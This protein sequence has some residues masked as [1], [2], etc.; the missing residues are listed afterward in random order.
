MSYRVIEGFPLSP[1]QARAWQLQQPASRLYAQ[2]II[3]IE[4][5]LD[6][7]ALERAVA[8]VAQRHEIFRTTFRALPEMQV[9]V[10]VIGEGATPAFR[11]ID[12]RACREAEAASLI[13]RVA[14]HDRDRTWDFE[15]GPLLRCALIVQ[16]ADRQTLVLTL[17]SL[18]ADHRTLTNV[19]DEIAMAYGGARRDRQPAEAAA[20]ALDPD[21]LQYV[22]VAEWQRDMVAS[23]DDPDA[24]RFWQQ[25]EGRPTER[26]ALRALFAETVGDRFEPAV[27][28]RDI[29]QR[30]LTRI[31][32]VTARERVSEAAFWMT[33]WT[34]LLRRL[35][36]ETD[37]VIGRVFH[38]RRYPEMQEGMGPVARCVPIRCRADGAMTFAML[39]GRLHQAITDADTRQE[40]Y[41]APPRERPL[42]FEVHDW[43]G[44]RR[45]GELRFRIEQQVC[46]L[47]P[48]ILKLACGCR[49]S[50]RR[51]E[52]HLDRSCVSL[53]TAEWLADHLLRIVEGVLV[54]PHASIEALDLLTESQRRQLL[55][56]GNASGVASIAVDRPLPWHV[57]AQAARTPDAAAV[58]TS[59]G[60]V[61]L[62]YVELTRWADAIAAA[63]R[64]RGVSV[65]S[66]VPVLMRRST[67]LLAALLG[68]MKAG[69]AYVPL[70]P[71]DPAA[72][73]AAVLD[74]ANA[75]VVLTDAGALDQ[76]WTEAIRGRELRVP[77]RYPAATAP[78][79]RDP[80]DS[81]ALALHLDQLAYVIY[82][83]GSSGQ[84]KGVLITHRGLMNYL[85]WA[86]QAYRISAGGGAPL[87]S[88]IAFDLSVT[89][90]FAPLLAGA[91]VTLAPDA[92]STSGD[93]L[94]HTLR[95]P[96]DRFDVVK[97][98]PAHL[99]VLAWQVPPQL[100][101]SRTRSLIVGGEALHAEALRALREA[102]TDLRIY[103]EY[104]PTETVVG[105]C[106][107]E[108]TPE[109]AP[110]GVVPIGRPIANTR[111]YVVDRQGRL[112][113]PGVDGELRIGGAGLARGYLHR[114]D[115]TADRFVP[116]PFGEAPGSRLYRTGDIVRWRTDGT[117]VYIGRADDQ[118]KLR[119]YRIE[120]GEI[121]SALRR[122]PGVR[123]VAVLVRED[124][125]GD[126]RLVAY[127]VADH[128][129]RLSAEAIGQALGLQLPHYMLP[130]AVV[131]LDA[132]PVTRGGKIDRPALPPPNR[133]ADRSVAI[134]RPATPVEDVLAAI[135]IDVLDLDEVSVEDNFFASGGDSIRAIQLCARAAQRGLALTH[136]QLFAHQ[137][138]AALARLVG[139]DQQVPRPP[140]TPP[141]FSLVSDTDRETL[142]EGLDDAYPM[143][144]LQ[145]GM[146][147]HTELAPDTAIFHD[148]HSFRVRAPLDL[149]GLR[150][151]LDE[152]TKRHPV[153]RTAFELSRYRVPLQLVFR[154][155]VAP[156]DVTDLRAL[157]PDAQAGEVAAWLRAERMRPFEWRAAPLLRF[158]VHWLRDDQFQFTMSFHHAMLDGW[159]AA[160]LL[161]ELF[162]RS[163]AIHEA[164]EAPAPAAL[165]CSFRDFIALERQAEES[166]ECRQ[167]WRDQLARAPLVRLPRREDDAT[168]AAETAAIDG[169]MGIVPVEI[170]ESVFEGLRRLV[171]VAALP[172]KSIAL[173]AH[174]KVLAVETNQP[175]VVTGLVSHG[176]P[177]G[178]DGDR[179]LGLFLNTVPCVIDVGSRSWRDLAQAA[180]DAERRLWP[181]RRYPLA[182]LQ[183]DREGPVFDVGFNFMHYH[184]YQ[185][186][187]QSD[188]VRV[189]GYAGYEETD[190]PLTAN[191]YLD[192]NTTRLRLSL[193]YRPTEFSE[194]QIGRI[195][196]RYRQ[197][198]IAIAANA[199]DDHTATT[200]LTAAERDLVVGAWSRGVDGM[201]AASLVA[202]LDAQAARTPAAIAVTCGGRTL[203]FRELHARANQL[204]RHL[205]TM[206]IGREMLVGVWL[207]RSPELL[208][209]LLG[210]LKAGA[211]YVPLDPTNPAARVQSIL[212]DARPRVVLTRSELI[213][214]LPAHDGVNLRIDA[215]AAAF[216]SQSIEPLPAASDEAD[217]ADDL[218]YVIYTSGST[219]IPKG[220]LVRRQGLHNYLQWAL[221][222]Y[223][224]QPG[225]GAPLHSSAAF[226]LSVTSLFAPL[227]TGGT[228][229]MAPEGALGTELA[230]VLRG[231]EHFGLIKLTPAHLQAL[232][233]QLPP[234]ALGTR[235][236][237]LVI[238]G[239]ALHAETLA[240]W[241]EA[242]PGLRLY[243]EYGPT[244]TVVGSV[245][246]DATGEASARGPVPIGRPIANTQI[247]VLGEHGHPVPP[248]V[249]GELCIGGV[250]VARGYLNRPELTADRF[251]PDP[252]GT[253]PGARLYRTG[254]IVR[255]RSD[256]IL[257]YLG[258]A[259][260]QVKIRGHRVELGEIESAL[261]QQAG[262]RDAV[263]L[264]RDVAP[265]DRRLVAYLVATDAPLT[266]ETLQQS[267]RQLLPDALIP[268][269]MVWLDELP[270]TVNGK[271]D[272][273]RLP[274]PGGERPTL[275]DGYVAPRTPTEE[276]LAAIWAEVLRLDRV[277][278]ED[279]FFALGG[280]SLIAMQVAARVR[281]AFRVDLP[282][283]RLF[284]T[285]RVAPLA[286][287][288]DEGRIEAATS[289]ADLVEQ[290]ISIGAAAAV[291]DVERLLD[292][293]EALDSD[294]VR[295]LLGDQV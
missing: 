162:Q 234:D 197:A 54:D 280:H 113:P 120:L 134:V 39:A 105:S 142:P 270:L 150:R 6:A 165:Q 210:I 56:T 61:V 170:P 250:G 196:D 119:G 206:G 127:L 133:A 253:T 90:L 292:E 53:A 240:A 205:Q 129:L 209:A 293:L 242:G 283:R 89:S 43:P 248:R 111:V 195:A 2:S 174:A 62:T 219:G 123:E 166:P 13:A 76:P 204:A 128:A 67:G 291:S 202:S 22:E 163:R 50:S 144:A 273:R 184:V 84:P 114:P 27:I 211:A 57:D 91:P 177:E 279:D 277:G 158:H 104:G 188:S 267:L 23:E 74:D 92:A 288:I 98:T 236:R 295:T 93:A 259:D 153:L 83:S 251:V 189:E 112:V 11:R 223:G 55:E 263:A 194:E 269:A 213:A 161:T 40:F 282:L 217:D 65:E 172:L 258:R 156:L 192:P 121:E 68:V 135:W 79:T 42:A 8:I 33:C 173:A 118:V 86:V 178:V 103:N 180:F 216:E 29:E 224:L 233:L 228:I 266:S 169:G 46:H 99:Q 139:F 137:T 116:D 37:L 16:A 72:R 237:A 268:S 28:A 260:Q 88:S 60:G 82:T 32:S 52:L 246:H 229:T 81:R 4:G 19:V 190:L 101:A 208:I 1:Q 51:L 167:F 80:A 20:A 244:E 222:A 181:H 14:A 243:N 201:P 73:I 154:E 286:R 238:G 183:R 17:P 252:F 285:P 18:C 38:G 294:S 164:P 140:A 110:A 87:H 225:D 5:A 141:A 290:Q 136:D 97:I 85:L 160:S 34:V 31:N 227:L 9:P 159:S 59:G 239:E 41:D 193:H 207:D 47:E 281:D 149:D 109:M 221:Q 230:E 48:F 212:A 255:W 70:D 182:R 191:F 262:I 45:S 71:A 214:R 171:R 249:A 179:V 254:D 106:V 186:V 235:T 148:L 78:D 152:V 138:I 115:L 200:L 66:R 26:S 215:D 96:G 131:W 30:Q 36:G 107:F 232:G 199:D 175:L 15:D 124:A 117:L 203:T 287:L 102:G 10:Q 95:E 284:E 168:L 157:E 143:G 146:V 132:L 44:V 49:D 94:V 75:A 185:G 155:V 247:Y 7:D 278:M 226:D 77:D 3:A 108:V 64:A 272:R 25:Q 21:P 151:S 63:L 264:L 35:L 69:A 220:V 198:L 245:A 100:V 145:S 265:D 276:R 231:H 58:R 130:Q 24:R 271:V 12:A 274:A 122:L 176:R 218:A 257:D 261:R 187:Q 256:G 147:F 289:T 275:A 241:R 126:R 125:P